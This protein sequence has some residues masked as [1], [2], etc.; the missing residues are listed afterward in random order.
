MCL[1]FNWPLPSYK[2]VREAGLPH[3]RVFTIGCMVS[4]HQET[5][6]LVVCV[7]LGTVSTVHR[8]GIC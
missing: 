7:A 1:K 8:W 6:K 4:E 5:G 3:A 2:V